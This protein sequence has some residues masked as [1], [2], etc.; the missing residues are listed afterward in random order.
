MK[1]LDDTDSTVTLPVFP[2]KNSVSFPNMM[3]PI[4]A[5]R[6]A[7]IAAVEAALATEDKQIAIF[8]QR[9]AT[10][11]EPVAKDLYPVGT[12]C[13][14]KRMQRREGLIQVMIQGSRRIEQVEV[15]QTSP[16]PQFQVRYLPEP[17][18]SGPEVEALHRTMLDLAARMLSLG[19]PQMQIDLEQ[20]VSDLEQPIQQAYVLSSMTSID[21]DKQNRLL[22][23]NTQ[24]QALQLVVDYLTHEVQVLEVQSQISQAV[25]SKMSKEQREMMLRQQLREIQAQLGESSPEQA[26]V[27]ELRR[28]VDEVSL[29]ELV[30]K[31]VDKELSRLERM[32]ANSADYQTSR[33]YLDLVLDMPWQKTTEDN[34][35]LARARDILDEDHFDLQEVK[36]RIIEH[37][38]VMKLNPQA[39]AP[40]LCF[41]GPP[42]VGKTSL[43]Q[44]IA[45]ALGR[46]FERMSLGGLHDEAE[47]RGHRRTYVGAMPGRIIRAIR[48][49]GV[50]NPLLML[51]EIDKMGRDYRGDPAAALMEILDPSQNIE[52]NDNYLDLPYDLSK[53]F[54]VATANTL[55]TIPAPLLD[56]IEVLRLSGYS[57]E[58]KRE[59]AKRYILGRSMQEAG[60]KQ[61]QLIIGDTVLDY[62]I[63][64]YTRE[65]GVRSLERAL[66]R[67]LRK[68]ASRVAE[69]KLETVTLSTEMVTEYLG[70][71]R[72]AR[73]LRRESLPC[74]VVAGLAWTEMGGDVLYVEAVLLPEGKDLVLTGQLGSVMQESAKAAQSYLWSQ[75]EALGIDKENIRKSGAH[76][77]V[78]A[79]ATPKDGPSAG[80]TMATALA[81]AY[82]GISVRSDTAMTGEITLSG[83]VLPVG[84]I[85][86]KLM[87]AHRAGFKRVILP[88]ENEVD[89][90]QLPMQVRTELEFI[91]AENIETVFSAAIPDFVLPSMNSGYTESNE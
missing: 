9:D 56:R 82:T 15:V 87:A 69:G 45:R 76:I 66:G 72:L 34:L 81:S 61:D 12:L 4:T 25:E 42:G 43:G 7:S 86:E 49:A 36:E 67:I 40:I 51:D 48:R 22:A 1:N 83:L 77:H 89:L 47:L 27:A 29:P 79:G 73:E 35:D 57:D 26:E 31:E 8:T 19:P 44:S 64:N 53:V 75:A 37:L 91:L 65:A 80:V 2:L 55:D 50:Q 60:L 78:P 33:S 70:P 63:Q 3:L 11:E 90:S 18:D 10:I 54:F 30:Q 71:A 28:R 68:L 14:I 62:I 58:E 85:K 16:F 41:V 6:P 88:K 46:V 74:G 21:I 5:G 84:G 32:S 52:F 17:E 23:A 38:A 13:V 39:K 59:I 20:M 24:L